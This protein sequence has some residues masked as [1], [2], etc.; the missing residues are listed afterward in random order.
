MTNQKA[1]KKW[2]SNKRRAEETLLRNDPE[3]AKSLKIRECVGRPRI[4][5]DQPGLLNDI[6]KIAT[7]GAACGDRGGM[8]YS[9]Q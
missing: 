9:E 6:L 1:V 7:I 5:V 4:E 2:R 3:L 8:I